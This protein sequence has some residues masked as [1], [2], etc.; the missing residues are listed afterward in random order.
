MSLL[1]VGTVFVVGIALGAVLFHYIHSQISKIEQKLV[2]VLNA[3]LLADKAS[4]RSSKTD[5]V[6]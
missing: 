5:Q 6:S 3:R 4:D 2:N 1:T